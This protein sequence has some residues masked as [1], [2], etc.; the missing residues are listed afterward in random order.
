M[1]LLPEYALTPDLFLDDGKSASLRPIFFAWLRY[2]LI[3]NLHAGQWRE[4]LKN[5][6]LSPAAKETFKWFNAHHRLISCAKCLPPPGPSTPEQWLEEAVKSHTNRSLSAVVAHES[7]YG[8]ISDGVPVVSPSNFFDYDCLKPATSLAMNYD[9]DQY[10]NALKNVFRRSPEVS[11]IDP[12]IDPMQ[13]EYKHFPKLFRCIK[14][15]R[16][17]SESKIRINI[18]RM[19][20]R[21]RKDGRPIT[22]NDENQW[23]EIFHEWDVSLKQLDLAA[24]IYIWPKFQSRY[25]LCSF[26]GILAGKGFKSNPNNNEIHHWARLERDQVDKVRQNFE[27]NGNTNDR[28]CN[29]RIG[30]I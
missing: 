9:I 4:V 15:H 20:G 24:E 28:V 17:S 5:A 14:D 21:G 13:F 8:E 12:Y 16:N 2:G 3:R 25:F 1:S 18:H 26:F 29:F 6:N 7:T 30:Q 23:R 22:I 27:P 10:C 11:F 19:N